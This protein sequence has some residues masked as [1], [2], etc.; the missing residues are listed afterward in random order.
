MKRNR[1][2]TQGQRRG[3]KAGMV[4]RLELPGDCVYGNFL[5]HMLGSREL[6]VENYRNICLFEADRI[7]IAC[8]ENRITIRGE[9]LTISYYLEDEIRIQGKINC[10]EFTR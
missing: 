3:L 1:D 10:I 2:D 5:L 8:K 9:E 4:R 6:I 7:V